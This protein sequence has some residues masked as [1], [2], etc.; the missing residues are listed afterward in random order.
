SW[1]VTFPNEDP[2][3]ECALCGACKRAPMREASARGRTTVLVGDGASDVKA[4]NVADVIFAKDD[5]AKWCTANGV[6]FSPF[7]RL[8]DVRLELARRRS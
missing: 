6:P 3:C 8:T 4:A 7:S 2:S 5:L 1:T